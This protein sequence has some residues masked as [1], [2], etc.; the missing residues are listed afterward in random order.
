M[1]GWGYD[2]TR[3]SIDTLIDTTLIQARLVG[4]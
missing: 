2:R 1:N 3:S 4:T